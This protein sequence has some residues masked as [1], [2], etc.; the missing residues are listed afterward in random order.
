MITRTGIK[1]LILSLLLCLTPI[2]R[3]AIA[4]NATPQ[5]KLVQFYMALL[6][7]GPNWAAGETAPPV[8]LKQQHLAYAGSLLDSGKAMVAGPLQDGGA[9]MG[10]YIFR[11]S[12]LEEA[13][14][15]AENDPLAK[16]G[17][18]SPEMHPWW[19]EDVMKRP[20]T[21][22]K[23]TTVYLVL[24]KRGQNWTAGK[25]REDAALQQAHLANIR[26]L[27]DLK[28]MVIAGPFGDDTDLRG[29]FVFRV[30]SA[31]EANTLCATDPMV[32]KGHLSAAIYGWQIPEGV[33]P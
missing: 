33:F 5:L 12:S 19:A 11:A 8:Q 2:S 25:T 3:T 29:I 23:I 7:R 16:A 15:W 17:L 13:K 4:Q 32:Q 30:S 21:P 6:R 22:L 9:L 10:I 31:A 26:R 27:A 14:A 20:S 28:K 18:V 1:A 24:L